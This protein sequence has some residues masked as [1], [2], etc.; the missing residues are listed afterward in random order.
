MKLNVRRSLPVLCLHI[1]IQQRIR[2]HELYLIHRKESAGANQS[3]R[4]AKGT[5][6]NPTGGGKKG[7]DTKHAVRVQSRGNHEMCWKNDA[8]HFPRL[9][10]SSD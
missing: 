7:G 8:L 2:K 6:R 3:A 10:P 9:V 5:I 1:E 4:H